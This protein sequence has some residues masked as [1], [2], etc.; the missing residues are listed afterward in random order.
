MENLHSKAI[1]WKNVGGGKAKD[2]IEKEIELKDHLNI[3]YTEPK[4]I[5]YMNRIK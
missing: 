1:E 3:D 5:Y 2:L 4:T